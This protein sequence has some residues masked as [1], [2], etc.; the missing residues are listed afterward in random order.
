[1]EEYNRC[2]QLDRELVDKEQEVTKATGKKW[3]PPPE[4]KMKV[5][6]DAS[7]NAKGNC[8]GL[9]IVARGCYWVPNVSE[10]QSLSSQ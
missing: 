7:V 5:N 8:I 10:N 1:L 6:W 9:G 4:R 2:L 3:T